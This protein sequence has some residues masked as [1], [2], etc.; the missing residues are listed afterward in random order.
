MIRVYVAN[1]AK[2]NA[3]ILKGKWIDLPCDDLNDELDDILGVDTEGNRI[4]EEYAIH[5]YETDI[6]GLKISEYDSLTT[7]DELAERVEDLGTGEQDTLAAIIAATGYDL[8]E[9]L[10]VLEK[11]N[12]SFYPGCDSLAD[13]AQY[14]VDEG[15]FGDTDQMGNLV[16]YID[17]EALGRDLG[18]DGY[19][20]TDKGIIRID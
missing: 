10:D 9:A 15:L 5:D 4:D 19:T 16:N 17:Y 1:L 7:L 6:E 3:G 8:G 11:G 2:Y 20:E 13:L 12:Y 18:F 14:M